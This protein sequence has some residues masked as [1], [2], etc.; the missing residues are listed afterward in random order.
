MIN[1]PGTCTTSGDK[2][3]WILKAQD[4]LRREHNIMGRWYKE[5]ITLTKYQNLKEAVRASFPYAVGNLS[6][7]NWR[8]YLK[9]RFQRKQDLISHE[10]GRL[11]NLSFS[12]NAYSPNLDE[13]LVDE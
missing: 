7:S 8:R 2:M 13:D 1:Y 6:N 12:D 10:I 9:N 5:G 11:R 4:L 3:A